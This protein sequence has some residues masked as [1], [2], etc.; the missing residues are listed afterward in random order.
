MTHHFESVFFLSF[1][2][3]P[4]KDLYK[5]QFLHWSRK[6]IGWLEEA[7]LLTVEPP[8]PADPWGPCSWQWH[9]CPDRAGRRP[10]PPS[11]N[12]WNKIING[13]KKDLK[14]AIRE[15]LQWPEDHR[16][17]LKRRM[18]IRDWC[19]NF[20]V[21]NI[22][23]FSGTRINTCLLGNSHMS[24][25]CHAT[26]CRRSQI[27]LEDQDVLGVEDQEVLLECKEQHV[28]FF[29]TFFFSI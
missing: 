23:R 10:M 3:S 29:C 24:H 17:L 5:T 1:C 22:H 13:T 20:C 8:Q 27:A 26:C 15:L 9:E 14:E 7:S 12:W 19:W 25:V 21:C 16:V 4:S 28:V 18:K 6:L 2:G 11:T